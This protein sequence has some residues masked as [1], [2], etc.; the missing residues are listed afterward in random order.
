MPL[1]LLAALVAA[2]RPLF[3]PAGCSLA[4]LFGRPRRRRSPASLPAVAV[5]PSAFWPPASPPL[6]RFLPVAA[7]GDQAFHFLVFFVSLSFLS[8]SSDVLVK[9]KARAHQTLGWIRDWA[10]DYFEID[11]SKYYP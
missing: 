2:A 7:S 4:A 1:P 10:A 6:A 9:L 5:L 11:R 3:I 8:F